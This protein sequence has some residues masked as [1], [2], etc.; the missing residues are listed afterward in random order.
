MKERTI[1]KNDANQRLDRFLDK[2]VPP[3]PASPCPNYPRP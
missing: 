3:L 2:A 1:G